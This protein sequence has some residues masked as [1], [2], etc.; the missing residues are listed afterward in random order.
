MFVTHLLLLRQQRQHVLHVNERTLNQPA[1][2]QSFHSLMVS[3]LLALLI[4]LVTVIVIA[5]LHKR[6][7]YHL[8]HVRLKYS[9]IYY[10][11]QMTVSIHL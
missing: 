1:D 9:N 8:F 6:K 7:K 5:T 11:K 3:R 10:N 4:S 2:T